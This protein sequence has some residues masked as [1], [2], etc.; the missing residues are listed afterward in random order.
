MF[1]CMK[2]IS[3][4]SIIISFYKNREWPGFLHFAKLRNPIWQHVLP[5]KKTSDN[6][7]FKFRLF[8][9]RH[10]YCSKLPHFECK[11]LLFYVIF[12]FWLMFNNGYTFCFFLNT[13]NAV[14]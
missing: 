8:L 1:F 7:D 10:N 12:V 11:L 9:K 2:N 5:N 14:I 13:S 4:D 3:A 6:L